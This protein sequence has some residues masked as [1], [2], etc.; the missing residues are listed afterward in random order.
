MLYLNSFKALLIP[1]SQHQKDL[2]LIKLRRQFGLD[3]A[4]ESSWIDER[5]ARL[6]KKDVGK[7]LAAVQSLKNKNKTLQTEVSNH[8]Q[9]FHKVCTVGKEL[10][11]SDPMK[12]SEYV[13]IVTNL[14]G[15][16]KELQLALQEREKVL[17]DSELL[18][19][20]KTV[21]I[22]YKGI[23]CVNNITTFNIHQLLT[24]NIKLW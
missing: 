15:K 21:A 8:E 9:R 13:N 1:L 10:A 16:W 24:F 3:A 6:L 23:T 7:D 11:E 14:I 20:V 18:Q 4:E 5:L 17:K 12:A 2:E 22:H 19:Q